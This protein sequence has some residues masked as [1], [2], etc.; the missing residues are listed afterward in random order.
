MS[1][2]NRHHDFKNKLL[3]KA[4]DHDFVASLADVIQGQASDPIIGYDWEGCPLRANSAG[5]LYRMHLEELSET[6][7][8]EFE[9]VYAH[10]Y[11]EQDLPDHFHSLGNQK[12]GAVS[13][14]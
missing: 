12:A 14:A 11:G 7:F 6:G 13:E 10:F 9:E 4:L 3:L 1:F 2:F 5:L 8:K